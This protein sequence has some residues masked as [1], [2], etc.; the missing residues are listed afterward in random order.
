MKKFLIR[1]AI[2]VLSVL[3][4]FLALELILRVVYKFKFSPRG[5]AR[6]PIVKTYRLAENKHLLYELVPNSKARIEGIDF[7][8]NAWGFRD[9]K[10][11]VSKGNKK[12]IIFIG[13]SLTYGWRIHLSETYHKRLERLL[14]SKGYGVEVMGMGVAGYNAVQE[15]YLIKEKAL[16]FNPDMIILQICPNDFERTVSIKKYQEGKKLVLVPYHDFS[17]PYVIKKGRIIEFLMKYSHL[18]KFIN[19][20]L[21]WLKRKYDQNYN[22]REVFLLGEEKSF[23]YLKKIINLLQRKDIQLSAVIFPVRKAKN[24]YPYA[25]LHEKIHNRLEEWEVPYLDLYEELNIKNKEVI[26]IGRLHPDAKGNELAAHKIFDFIVP[27]LC[28]NDE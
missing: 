7:E 12:R 22:P 25:S 1:S 24:V 20:K 18:Y 28:T 21:F 2:I 13:D 27:L 10:Y 17:I 3:F 23:R 15:Y 9:N 19:L 11:R 4:T 8:I 26:W 5:I 6:L 14:N 16:E